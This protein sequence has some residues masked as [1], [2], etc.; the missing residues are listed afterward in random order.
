MNEVL[1]KSIGIKKISRITLGAMED[2]GYVVN[3]TAADPY[4]ID[5]I[6]AGCSIVPTDIQVRRRRTKETVPVPTSKSSCRHEGDAYKKAVE[7]G[8]NLRRKVYES[9]KIQLEHATLPDGVIY[10][11]NQR[12]VVT[13]QS[14]DGSICTATIPSL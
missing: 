5:D 10:V 2:M 8:T 4:G 9:H 7:H 3:Y 14:E 12:S 1:S 11:G 13:Y 6:G